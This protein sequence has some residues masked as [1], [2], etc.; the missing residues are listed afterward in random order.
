MNSEIIIDFEQQDLVL[1]SIGRFDEIWAKN[2]KVPEGCTLHETCYD[3]GDLFNDNVVDREIAVRYKQDQH[4]LNKRDAGDQNLTDDHYMLMRSEVNA[5]VLRERCI[6]GVYVD[7]VQ[8]L[9]GDHGES[10]QDLKKSSGFEDL[11]L[12]KGHGDL[13]EAL[14]RMHRSTRKPRDDDAKV[15]VDLIDGK[16]EGKIPS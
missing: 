7:L 13:V 10:L 4:L 14:V 5:W 1:D 2:D 12:P 8:D 6:F 16:G 3:C 9:D 11:V 15:Q